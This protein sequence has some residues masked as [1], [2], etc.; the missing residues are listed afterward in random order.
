MY[1][2]CCSRSI[3]PLDEIKKKN[4][5]YRGVT[6]GLLPF[7]Y[8]FMACW[9]CSFVIMP[10]WTSFLSHSLSLPLNIIKYKSDGPFL[11]LFLCFPFSN[12]QAVLLH[13]I[14]YYCRGI[15]QVYQVVSI[16]LLSYIIKLA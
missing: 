11:I 2:L 14:R 8:Y 7:D 16:I 12:F 1:Y 4:V 10:M 3:G 9:P 13:H 6:L 15:K 5:L